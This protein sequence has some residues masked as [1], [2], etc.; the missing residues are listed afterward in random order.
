[1]PV[2]ITG[3]WLGEEGNKGKGKG[4]KRIRKEK[5]RVEECKGRIY[6]MPGK[7]I[8]QIRTFVGLLS[9][10]GKKNLEPQQDAWSSLLSQSKLFLV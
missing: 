7:T 3:R 6:I 4:K 5:S 10:E 8:C 1:M 2:Y 9:E